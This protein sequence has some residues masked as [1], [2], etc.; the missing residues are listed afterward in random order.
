MNTIYII[1]S[2][3]C[4]A[5]LF[6]IKY[7]IELK[8]KY[9]INLIFYDVYGKENDDFIKKN[10]KKLPSKLSTPMLYLKSK[11]KLIRLKHETLIQNLIG[12]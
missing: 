11:D 6:V 3:E 12:K 4:A 8:K 1:G 9:E 5:C 2:T 7:F 10:I